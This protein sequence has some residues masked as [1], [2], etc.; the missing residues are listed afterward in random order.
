[1][2]TSISFLY[3]RDYT[4]YKK[5]RRLTKIERSTF[6]IQHPL[7]EIMIGLLLGDGHI[8]QRHKKHRNSRFMYVQSSLRKNHYNYFKHILE[9]LN[10]ISL[11]NLH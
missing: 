5:K 3:K 8:Q 10:I 11:T 2:I 6:N 7:N 1:M 9:F 4:I